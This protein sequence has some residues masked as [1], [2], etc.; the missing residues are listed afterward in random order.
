MQVPTAIS[1][2]DTTYNILLQCYG[3]IIVSKK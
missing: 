3:A 1:I 2:I